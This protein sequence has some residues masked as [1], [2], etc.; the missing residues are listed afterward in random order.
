MEKYVNSVIFQG[1]PLSGASV[2]VLNYPSG[3]LA[4][5]YIDN[6]I[7]QGPNPV[8]TDVNGN[9][10]FY[11]ANGRY[12]LQ[13]SYPNAVTQTFLDF[14]LEY[15]PAQATAIVS[16]AQFNVTGTTNSTS[17]TTGALV[18]SG[19]AGIALDLWVGGT[20]HG[21]VAIGGGA[22]NSTPIGATTPSTGS[23]TQLTDSGL[24]AHGVVLGNSPLTVVAPGSTTTVLTS[25]G[26]S[27][28]P[29][30]QAIPSQSGRL[31]NVQVF[32]SSGTY[33]STAGT[34]SIIV[35]GVGQGGGGGGAAAT[36]ASTVAAA[37]GGT[38]GTYARGRFTTGFTG[39]LSVTI[40]SGSNGGAAGNNNG[41]A[42]ANTSL[43]AIFVCPGGPGG[44]GSS[45]LTWSSTTGAV[46]GGSGGATGTA[47]TGGNLMSQLGSAGNGGIALGTGVSQSGAGGPSEFSGSSGYPGGTG[48]RAGQLYGGGGAGANAQNSQAAQAGG[49]GAA[50]ILIIYEYA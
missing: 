44:A 8:T 36:G 40:G 34:N 31:L 38:G 25:T 3:T 21:N 35:E 29:T 32:T 1:N 47:A 43:G 18:D 10:A 41:S 42:G 11:A 16:A 23:F 45:A 17:P 49:V 33:N 50:G 27:S 20:I 14:P 26:T 2:A 5:I 30:F 6:G 48:S 7:T 39:G 22:I 13:I 37:G 12:S 15:D 46:F 9:Y 28:D 19:G 4:T 24:T